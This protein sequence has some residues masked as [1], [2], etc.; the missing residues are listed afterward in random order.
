MTI[1]NAIPIPPIRT[2][3]GAAAPSKGAGASPVGN[4]LT[5]PV[6]VP[7]AIGVSVVLTAP[8]VD[9]Y[10]AA[11]RISVATGE[12]TGALISGKGAVDWGPAVS[13]AT[14]S[15]GKVTMTTEVLRTRVRVTVKVEVEVE[16]ATEVGSVAGRMPWSWGRAV[17]RSGR[18]RENTEREMCG[19]RIG[20]VWAQIADMLSRRSR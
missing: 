14:E 19:E 2:A 17:A 15:S 16:V 1:P 12:T 9:E 10:G 6:P 5:A 4:G 11:T 7:V 8:A 3:C 20:A 18:R 13:G